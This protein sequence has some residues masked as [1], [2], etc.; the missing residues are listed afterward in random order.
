MV[1]SKL[2]EILAS[3]LFSPK[4]LTRQLEILRPP[5]TAL[6]STVFRAS[7]GSF[8]RTVIRQI[9][10][11]NRDYGRVVPYEHAGAVPTGIAQGIS[12]GFTLPRIAESFQIIA[13]DLKKHYLSLAQSGG[14]GNYIAENLSIVNTRGLQEILNKITRRHEIMAAQAISTGKITSLAGDKENFELDFGF[15][16]EQLITL[17]GNDL[18]TAATAKIVDNLETWSRSI[19]QRVSSPVRNVLMGSSVLSAIR[20]NAK[21]VSLLDRNSGIQTGE[22]FPGS[23][24]SNVRPVGEI[25][26]LRLWEYSDIY[27]SGNNSVFPADRV[28]LFADGREFAKVHFSVPVALSGGNIPK[29][30]HTERGRL[31]RF[32]YDIY[33]ESVAAPLIWEPGAFISAKV[34]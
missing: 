9:T 13:S 7:E 16:S 31:E 27:G 19:F 28:V 26:G 18:W 17:G 2:A 21:I 32:G 20:G 29:L 33:G 10:K 14:S 12:K 5:T 4:A 24:S 3:P 23:S 34:V 22:L 6:L 8:E 11:E 30:I 25:A 15:T 1:D